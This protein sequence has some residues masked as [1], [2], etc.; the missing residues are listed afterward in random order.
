MKKLRDLL[1][2][3]NNQLPQLLFLVNQLND[4][5][6]IFIQKKINSTITKKVEFDLKNSL[7]IMISEIQKQFPQYK[8]VGSANGYNIKKN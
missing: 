7:E 1:T 4:C 8:I 6:Q 5:Y 2:E 3:D